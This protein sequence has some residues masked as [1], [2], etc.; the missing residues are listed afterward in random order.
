M[1]LELSMMALLL[2]WAM[3]S[4]ASEET[5]KPPPEPVGASFRQEGD[6]AIYQAI[7]A[8]R[9]LDWAIVPQPAPPDAIA[10]LVEPETEEEDNDKT[11]EVFWWRLAGDG[12]LARV[13]PDLSEAATSVA[14]FDLGADGLMEILVMAGAEV[15]AVGEDGSWTTV[16]ESHYDVFA[17]EQTDG[18]RIRPKNGQLFLRSV[19]LLQAVTLD[20]SSGMLRTVWQQE[21]P[22]GVNRRWGGLRLESP[23]VAY[24]SGYE[25][26]PMR[27]VVGPEALGA[28]RLRSLLLTV[29]D[30]NPPL[31]LEAWSRF[32]NLEELEESWFVSFEGAPAL[33]VTTVL[34]DKHGVFE[35]KK[36]RLFTL[37]ADRTR[38]G[39]TPLLE[40]M[41]KSRNWYG[42]C[43]GIADINGDG[44]DDVVSAQ[45]KG[46]GAGKL[47]VE[48]HL[49]RKTRGFD[50]K[51]RGSEIPV[52][53]GEHCTLSV[54]VSGDGQIDLVIVEGSD[55]LVFP[56]IRGA[57]EKAVVA[58]SPFWRARF[59]DID[60]RPRPARLFH[61]SMAQ[62]VLLG[63]TE[64]G[65]QAIRVVRFHEE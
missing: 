31:S 40:T 1:R 30:H 64:G 25:S 23:S 19:G 4:R 24:W 55:L 36:L 42:T 18:S 58:N 62:V 59:H 28:R 10:L 54:D 48:A 35:K 16:L 26:S 53:E 50:P 45:P 61:T 63:H 27:L 9:I 47:W 12:V 65:R 14:A 57:K 5:E 43:A 37:S 33:L 34:A 32:S 20:P 56:L 60:G 17:V 29:D 52:D 7:V 2:L 21:L 13:G 49:A 11:R 41:T 44:L 22:V 15:L 39:T 38:S 3:P 6:L 51:V 46:L 8:G